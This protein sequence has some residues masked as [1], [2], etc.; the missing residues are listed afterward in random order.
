MSTFKLIK[1]RCGMVESLYDL[2]KEAYTP[3]EWQP[4]LKEIADDLGVTFVFL[5]H[6]TNPQ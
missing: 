5:H 3:W 6:L 2:Y 4:K 1:V